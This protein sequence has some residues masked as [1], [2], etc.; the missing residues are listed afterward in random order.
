MPLWYLKET[1]IARFIFPSSIVARYT[2][3]S[4]V[5]SLLKDRDSRVASLRKVCS[6]FFK[7]LVIPI[8][9]EQMPS[10]PDPPI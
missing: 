1:Y 3:L 9:S 10:L 6:P 4:F 5:K 2:F 8:I 7:S